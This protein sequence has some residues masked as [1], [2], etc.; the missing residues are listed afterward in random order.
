MK[1][2]FLIIKLL[3]ICVS[4]LNAQNEFKDYFVYKN[5]DTINCKITKAK[6]QKIYFSLSLDNKFILKR[7]LSKNIKARK[8]SLPKNKGSYYTPKSLTFYECLDI[9]LSPQSKNEITLNKIEKPEEGYA[10]VYF[11][12]P[13]I[14]IEPIGSFIIREEEKK[15]VNLKTNSSYLIKVKAG[16]KHTYSTNI[17]LFSKDEIT[18]LAEN[19]RIYYIKATTE[20]NET[21]IVNQNINCE[22]NISINEDKYSELQLLTM[23]KKPK[24][25]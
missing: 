6:N 16:T 14:G 17:N 2:K 19:Q 21:G 13:Y 24:T 3:V 4:T 8:S 5:G 11:Y 25:Y 1:K 23:Y 20:C 7:D 12:K 15:L 22:R 9:F 18:I 10:Y